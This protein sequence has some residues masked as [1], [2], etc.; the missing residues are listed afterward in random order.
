MPLKHCQ[1]CQKAFPTQ[2][3]V[4]QHISASI[5]CLKEWH[6]DIVRKNDNRPPKHRRI[7]SPEPDLPSNADMTDDLPVDEADYQA[8]V[9]DADNRDSD[10]LATPK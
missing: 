10:D 9:D 2:R 8:S 3:A 4:N 5:N 1:F 7:H 6:K